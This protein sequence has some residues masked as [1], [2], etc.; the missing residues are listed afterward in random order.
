M[1]V[2]VFTSRTFI[3]YFLVFS[4][5]SSA[6]QIDAEGLTGVPVGTGTAHPLPPGLVESAHCQLQEDAH[7]QN[8]N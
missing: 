1:R 7:N 8:S 4:H 5:E 6:Q 2:W 3:L